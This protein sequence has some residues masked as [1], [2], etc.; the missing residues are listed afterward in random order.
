M[1][2]FCAGA[3]QFF[4]TGLASFGNKPSLPDVITVVEY[5]LP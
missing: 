4:A 3:R 2:T 1:N 5:D